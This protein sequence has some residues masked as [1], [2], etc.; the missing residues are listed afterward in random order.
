MFSNSPFSATGYGCQSEQ[1]LRSLTEL[2]HSVDMACSY[3]VF[4]GR[5]PLQTG[6]VMFGSGGRPPSGEDRIPVILRNHTYDAVI[7]LSNC[8]ALDKNLWKKCK[9]IGNFKLFS[10]DPVERYPM[11]D[12]Q[13]EW[14]LTTGSS[15][16]PLTSFA[17]EEADRQGIQR[18]GI[19]PHTLHEEYQFDV[20]APKEKFGLP[21]DRPI[22]GIVGANSGAHQGWARK[23]FDTLFLAFAELIRSP[24]FEN[25]L[26]WAH[27]NATDSHSGTDLTTLRKK[28]GLEQD[29]VRFTPPQLTYEPLNFTDM[30]K[31]YKCMDVSIN[32]SKAEGFG[33][34]TIESQACGTPVITTKSKLTPGFNYLGSELK[35]NN[36]MYDASQCG[37]IDIPSPTELK[38]HLIKILKNPPSEEVRRKQSAKVRE[39]FNRERIRD[40]CW[41]PLLADLPEAV[42]DWS[43]LEKENS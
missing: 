42:A 40:E 16:I 38:E 12:G 31:A 11:T 6:G 29:Q 3:G 17:A 18:T 10:I 8:W 28:C 1:L 34:T 32:A 33:L 15:L 20:E 39:M 2:G 23:A 21:T 14:Y 43:I 5:Y 7:T 26:I 19:I 37:F 24:K 25:S 9:D 41:K 22:I 13:K 36:P 35:K 27:T 4:G 30:A